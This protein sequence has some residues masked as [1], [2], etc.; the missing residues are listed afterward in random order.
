MG[1]LSG[2]R[3]ERKEI[4]PPGAFDGL[5]DDELERALVDA[6]EELGLSK[7]QH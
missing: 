6:L 4:G 3:V 5:T 7:T 1:V 2:Q